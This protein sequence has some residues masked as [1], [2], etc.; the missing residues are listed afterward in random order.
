MSTRVRARRGEGERLREEILRVAE[1][2]LVESGSEDALTLRAVARL[3]GVTTPSVYL[4]FA[5]KEALVQAVC[6]RSW[7]ELRERMH[8]AAASA[9]DPFL[10]LGRCGHA[11]A[12]FALDHP[13]QYRL[14]M[15]RPGSP[16]ASATCFGHMVDG[17]SACVSAGVLRGD[18][19][20]LALGLWSALHGCVSLLIAQPG[21]AWPEDLDAF[22]DDTIR[23]AG[24]GSALASR[25]PRRTIPAA[26][27]L[28]TELDTFAARLTH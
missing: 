22:I 6:L 8:A 11:Y 26:A 4:H 25:L 14:L 3:A 28:T 9:E 20:V 21:F 17:V 7:N 16:Q 15:M 24:L 19:K 5:D 12:R 27:T 23:M 1:E 10:A 2:L 18:P 13:V